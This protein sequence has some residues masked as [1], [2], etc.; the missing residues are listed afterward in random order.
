NVCV[1]QGTTRIRP[2][3][4]TS[5]RFRSKTT[6]D[7]AIRSS[8]IPEG[9]SLSMTRN[10][11][12]P[13]PMAAKTHPS[14]NSTN[15]GRNSPHQKLQPLIRPRRSDFQNLRRHHL[16]DRERI[17]IHAGLQV[18]QRRVVRQDRA[19]QIRLKTAGK[20]E[21]ALVK[22]AASR[23]ASDS[24]AVGMSG[25]KKS[26]AAIH[27]PVTDTAHRLLQADRGCCSA[28]ESRSP[29]PALRKIAVLLCDNRSYKARCRSSDRQ[30]K[31]LELSRCPKRPFRAF[32]PANRF[33]TCTTRRHSCPSRAKR[34]ESLRLSLRSRCGMSGPGCLSL[35]P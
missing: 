23:P 5:S 17:G 33:R 8:R 3:T 19:A 34:Y 7:I 35:S 6:N 10:V 14:K 27:C 4:G 25:W 2:L 22:A 21:H 11:G 30:Q 18:R 28:R 9:R 29:G 32:H 15:T 31:L 1:A 16:L 26:S 13:S 20:R 24:A 12:L